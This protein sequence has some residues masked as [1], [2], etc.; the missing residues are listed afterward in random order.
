MLSFFYSD[1]LTGP[2]KPLNNPILFD[3]T[4]S[5]PAGAII[6]N[7]GKL[8]CPVQQSIRQY[9]EAVRLYQID[10]LMPNGCFCSRWSARSTV[11]HMAATP[12]TTMQD[13]K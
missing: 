11:G 8:I 5:R 4:A 9:G 6:R 2:W 12:T 3:A 13:L 7:N 10:S 1:K